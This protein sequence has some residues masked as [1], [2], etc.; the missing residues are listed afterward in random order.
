[1]W[2][3]DGHRDHVHVRSGN[4]L[5][6]IGEHRIDTEGSAGGARRRWAVG[7]ERSDLILRQCAQCG[8]VG[9]GGPATLGRDADDPD[10]QR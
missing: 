10:T 5:L 9:S 4:Q 7:A 3:P 8:D 2:D 1:M 6:V